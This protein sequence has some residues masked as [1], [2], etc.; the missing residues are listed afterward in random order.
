VKEVMLEL[1]NRLIWTLDANGVRYCHWKENHI[2]EEGLAGDND[3]DLLV[4]RAGFSKFLELIYSLGFKEAFNL[5][6][7]FP[8]VYHFYG[9]DKESGKLLHI[10]AFTK[11]I[12]G[13]SHTK[14]FHF[15]F[16][17]ALLATSMPHSSG[18]K[19][20][21][22][23]MELMLY[24]LRYYIKVSCVPG[25]LGILRDRADLKRELEYILRNMD[26]T[27]L[28]KALKE[29][30]GKVVDPCFWFRLLEGVKRRSVWVQIGQ[31]I[32]LKNKIFH[33]RRIGILRGIA[34]R[35]YQLFYRLINKLFLKQKKIFRSGGSI[36][37]IT[38][39]DASGKSTTVSE[40]SDWLC[41]HFNLRCLHVGRPKP[42]VLT[43]SVW[44]MLS[45]RK[46]ISRK[47]KRGNIGRQHGGVIYA[48][49]YLAL[50]YERYRLLRKAEQLRY[51]G[52]I[53]IALG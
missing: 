25:L 37:A 32:L 42:T 27:E 53:V 49:R 6:I 11:L 9:L 22:P 50:A 41:Q 51:K 40:L 47:G 38:G 34:L 8:F 44:L 16:E 45:C 31:G 5:R 14:N 24:V 43:F 19:V 52:F 20:P 28:D 21:P 30:A 1:S 48:L 29:V 36:L 7:S 35:H 23:E 13:E 2:L 17:R 26:Q 18:C 4:E 33:L 15:P 3:L 39:L 46:L 10:H 12:T